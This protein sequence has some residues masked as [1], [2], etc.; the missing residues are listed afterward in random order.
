M[1]ARDDY[2]IRIMDHGNPVDPLND[3]VD[4]FVYFADGKKYVAT[5][6]TA[7]NIAAI[8]QRHRQS[9]ESANGAYFWAADAIIVERLDMSTIE[10]VVADLLARDIFDKAFDGPH[11]F[12]DHG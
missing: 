3:N 8:M 5:F 9:G 2:S 6:F 1:G 11:P 10:R 4:V 7:R 12:D